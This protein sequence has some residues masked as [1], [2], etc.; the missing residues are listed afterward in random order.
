VRDQPAHGAL[1][2]G[3]PARGALV[4]ACAAGL[5]AHGA[6]PAAARSVAR[7]H[8]VA[9][10]A[11]A[12]GLPYAAACMAS[13]PGAATRGQPARPLP[14]TADRGQ[15]ARRA[16]PSSQP[17]AE[18]S[19]TRMYRVPRR[20]APGSLACRGVLPAGPG[21]HPAVVVDRKDTLAKLLPSC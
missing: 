20:P 6:L 9:A 1:A 5:P 19:P 14:G 2:T 13:L 10:G 3:L 16:R 15:P 18:P 12:R 21:R 17:A 7:G 11:A 4:A 8:G